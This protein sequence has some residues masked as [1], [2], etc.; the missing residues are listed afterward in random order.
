M[1]YIHNELLTGALDCDQQLVEPEAIKVEFVEVPL[2]PSINY[3]LE[4]NSEKK[5][6]NWAFK[7]AFF[8]STSSST[9]IE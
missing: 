1:F 9:H 6:L 7:K 5:P 8:L 4:E 2:I 3:D